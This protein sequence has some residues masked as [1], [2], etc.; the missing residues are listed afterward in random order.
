MK[1]FILFLFFIGQFSLIAQESFLSYPT[2]IGDTRRPRF[3]FSYFN[4]FDSEIPKSSPNLVEL[5]VGATVPL[6]DLSLDDKKGLEFIFDG[7]FF[8]QFDLGYE[9]DNLGW[10]GWFAFHFAYR[11]L[12]STAVKFAYRHLSSHL[13]DEYIQRTSRKRIGYTREDFTLAISQSLT[14][15]IEFYLEYGWAFLL[16]KTQR[17][18]HRNA[19]QAGIQFNESYK[20]GDSFN[21]YGGLDVQSFED[22]SWEPNFSIEFGVNFPSKQY[23]RSYRVALLAYFGRAT[24]GEFS[25]HKESYLGLGMWI[26]L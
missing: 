22:N 7:G 23:I 2:Y 26:N 1:L 10:D 15:N 8:G 18:Q 4:S 21:Y 19:I 13:G 9:K 24:I 6:W 25:I 5:Q 11:F 14:S 16:K 17:Y 12:P 20:H 3:G